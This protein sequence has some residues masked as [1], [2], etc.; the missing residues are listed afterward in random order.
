MF[1]SVHLHHIACLL[2]FVVSLDNL[3]LAVLTNRHGADI[4]LPLQLLGQPG[5]HGQ[6][7][8]EV[9]FESF[10]AILAHKRIELHDNGW[11]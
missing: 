10:A 8:T 11:I 7:C 3:D 4:A 1:L 5:R 6:R 9:M 2:I